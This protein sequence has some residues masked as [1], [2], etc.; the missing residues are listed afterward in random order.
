MS[1]SPSGCSPIRFLHRPSRRLIVGEWKGCMGNMPVS[2]TRPKRCHAVIG[3]IWFVPQMQVG[4][5]PRPL[6][7]ENCFNEIGTDAMTKFIAAAKQF[8]RGEEGATMVEY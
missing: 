8:A 5:N 3:A 7:I 6:H 2:P 4:R 1:Y